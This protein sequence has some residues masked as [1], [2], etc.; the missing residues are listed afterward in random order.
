MAKNNAPPV[1]FF[2]LLFF[3]LAGGGYWFLL[4]QNRP[5][6]NNNIVNNP[7]KK[8][9]IPEPANQIVSNLDTSLPNPNI[10]AMD[11]SV[12]MV[13]LIKLMENAYEQKY[14]N[15]PITYGVP[16]GRP[17]GSNQGIKNLLENRVQI[18][19]ISRTLRPEES[20]QSNIKLIPIAKDALAVVVGINNPYKGSLTLDQLKD[21]YQGKIINWSEVGGD[22][23]PIKVINRSPKSGSYN[24]FQDVV[25]LGESFLPDSS[26]FITYQRDVTTPI[27][28]ELNNNGIS[29]TTVA[30]AKNQ[31]TVR[32]MPINDISPVDKTTPNN[33]NYPLNRSVFLAVPNQT[34]LAVKNF[35]ELA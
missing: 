11:G 28:R 29:Y 20:S 1:I 27:L 13:K 8:L 19:A 3:L 6:T 22:D 26:N 16:E 17:N 23:L 32:I 24:F 34:S 9:S 18:A 12:T 14:P 30:Q 10:L 7:S 21:I 25:L 15:I 5:D 4:N 35:L 33:D 2:I 31:T